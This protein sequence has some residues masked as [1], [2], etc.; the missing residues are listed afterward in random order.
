MGV[1][2][3]VIS[4]F[5]KEKKVIPR[6][7]VL[8]SIPV[9]NPIIE[10]ELVETGEVRL[11]IPRPKPKRS[12]FFSI[13]FQVPEHKIVMLDAIGAEVWEKCDGKRRVED[14]IKELANI[15]NLTRKEVEVSLFSYLQQLVR[16]GYIGLQLTKGKELQGDISPR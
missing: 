9:R 5:K 13:F 6:E 8:S 10:W 3:K 2:K 11:S 7:D 15:H 14:L 12:P 1:I 4:K 16:R